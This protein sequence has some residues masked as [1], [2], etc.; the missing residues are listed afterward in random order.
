MRISKRFRLGASQYELDFVDIDTARDLPV[1][2]DPHFLGLRS[3]RWSID[4]AASVR[5]FFGRFIELLRSGRK[6]D[7]RQL[8][9]YLGEP[10]ETCLG[11]SRGRP[12]GN[13]VG[14][15]L[16]DQIFDSLVDSKAVQTGVL[17]DLEDTRVF[18]HGIDKDRVSDMTTVLIRQHLLQYTI[19]QCTLWGIPLTPDVPSGDVWDASNTLWTSH[20]T[21]RL[22]VGGRPILFVPKGVVSFSK[23]YTAQKYH[24]HF[25]LTYLKHEHLRL[26]TALVQRRKLR[27]GSIKRWVTKK[28]IV[29]HESPGDKD[30]LAEFT[31]RHVDV[32]ADFK[33][34][35]VREEQSLT[36]DALTSARLEDVVAHLDR[37]LTAIPAGNDDAARYHRLV[38]GILELCFYPAL[39]NPRLETPLHQGRKRIDITFDNS[40]RRGFFYS[41]H[42]IRKIPSAYIMIEC[43]NYSRDVHNP[44]LDQLAGRF[45]VNRGQ[46]GLLVS[47]TV[48][49]VDT[50][51]QRCAD[52]YKDGR[53]LIVPLQDEDLH[54]MLANRVQEVPEPYGDILSDRARRVAMA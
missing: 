45:G 42:T 50:L 8:F 18:V 13:A 34:N 49:D 9:S 5:S 46:F 54:H 30:Y 1:F 4:A 33:T 11:L 27:N 41:L 29:K 48:G 32:F 28:S 38:M 35:V 3:D 21:R 52:A 51:V 39:I 25:V 26:D 16:A 40:A 12:R 2:V 6:A 14:R 17:T 15:E 43:K 36:D 23:R 37:S 7:A 20:L 47:R 31:E 24:Q 22:V 53:G 10:N 44:E 19:D